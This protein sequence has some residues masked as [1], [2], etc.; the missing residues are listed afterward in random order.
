MAH[1]TFQAGDLTAVIGDNED[2][3]GRR[4]GYNG[5]HR[6][7]HRTGAGSL[8]GV[9]GLNHE[10]I[11][12]GEQDLRGES[13][14]FFEPRNHPIEFKRIS[15]VE[16]ELHQ[17]P[18]PTFFL[19]SWS[20]FKLVAPHYVDFS[21]RCKP[22]QHA[23]KNGWIGLFWASYILAPEN[24]SI[25][26]RDAKDWVQLCTQG[27]NVQST[28]RHVDD[29]LDL[30]FAPGTR[31]TLYRNF[32]SLRFRDPLYYG[33]SGNHVYV[34]MFDRAEGIRFSHSP[35]SGGVP[36]YPNPAWDWQYII[37]KYE[38]LQEYGYR[39]RVVYREKCSREEILREYETWRASL[40]K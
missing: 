23:F 28:V 14:V 38:V 18:T 37:P 31:D 10:H 17:G 35:S 1:E 2:Y 27:H 22:H 4:Y 3:D 19:E 25:Y 7:V 9:A 6:L 26:F 12:D 21:Y 34:L 36:S 29:K 16:A 8:F 40:G 39:A 20:R 15:E 24:K 32:S 30:A 11:F 33:I 5:V 13:K